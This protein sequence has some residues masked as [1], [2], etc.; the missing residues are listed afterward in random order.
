MTPVV[1]TLAGR[2]ATDPAPDEVARVFDVALADL[3]GDGVWAEEL[4]A[5][6][7]RQ[8][9]DGRPGRR[10]PGLV[11]HGG[12]RDHLGRHRPGPDRTALPGPRRGRSRPAPAALNPAREPL[13]GGPGTLLRPLC[14][15]GI[16]GDG[17]CGRVGAATACGGTSNCNHGPEGNS[18]A[19]LEIGIFKSGRQ[20]LRVRRHRHRPQPPD[21]GPRGRRHLLADRRLPVRA[22]PHGLGHGRGGQPRHRH[23]DRPPRRPRRPQPRGTVDPL[24]GP[25]HAL[26]RD[27]RAARREGDRPD[28]ADVRRAG[29]ARS[30]SPSASGR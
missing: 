22:P 2:P 1:A 11:L 13:R 30:S 7:G 9:A 14:P 17:R 5:V 23:R 15:G 26:R 24:R 6:P 21:P 20:G 29:P 25:D 10:V 18:V 27:P 28:A 8:G 12:G 19:E 3:V 4:W 16:V